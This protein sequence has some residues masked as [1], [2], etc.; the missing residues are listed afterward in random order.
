MAMIAL[1]VPTTSDA[2]EAA[3]RAAYFATSVLRHS[4]EHDHVRNALVERVVANAITKQY[5]DS[6]VRA[7]ESIARSQSDLGDVTFRLTSDIERLTEAGHFGV[8]ALRTLC[9]VLRRF[10]TKFW[11]AELPDSGFPEGF[12]HADQSVLRLL[13]TDPLSEQDVQVPNMPQIAK[14]TGLRRETTTEILDRLER[15]GFVNHTQSEPD[16]LPVFALTQK[17]SAALSHVTTNKSPQ[18]ALPGV[19]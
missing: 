17:G 7:L 13:N 4:E 14:T 5:I 16:T 10:A 12:S 6:D 9:P 8:P 2:L 11:A 19:S 18:V 3:D 15:G 1:G